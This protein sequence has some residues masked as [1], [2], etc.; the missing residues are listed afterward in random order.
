MARSRVCRFHARSKHL[1]S[2]AP[3]ANASKT[4]PFRQKE[5][6]DDEAKRATLARRVRRVRL[7]ALA[8]TKDMDDDEARIIRYDRRGKPRHPTRKTRPIVED[9]NGLKFRWRSLV[10]E[11]RLSLGYV[12]APV[13]ACRSNA[14]CRCRPMGLS[15]VTMLDEVTERDMDELLEWE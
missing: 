7:Y 10:L 3:F 5:V 4:S 11:D 1:P 2:H 9:D 6:V 12:L 8:V 15:R 13:G 14:V